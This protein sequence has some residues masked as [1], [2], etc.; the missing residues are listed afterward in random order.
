MIKMFGCSG[1]ALCATASRASAAAATDA[2]ER[3]RRRCPSI[4]GV[5]CHGH[6]IAPRIAQCPIAPIF[7]M[8]CHCIA[9][10]MQLVMARG[11]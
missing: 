6:S 1:F 4:S 11:C 3:V 7:R 8:M 5:D 9:T 2:A 10:I